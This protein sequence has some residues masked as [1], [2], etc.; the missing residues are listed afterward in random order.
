MIVAFLLVHEVVAYYIL[1]TYVSFSSGVHNSKPPADSLGWVFPFSLVGEP[2][3]KNLDY[4][5]IISSLVCCKLLETAA[6]LFSL[7]RQK[8]RSCCGLLFRWWWARS[9]RAT[10]A[11]VKPGP[12][13]SPIAVCIITKSRLYILDMV[14]V[15]LLSLH[16]R[17]TQ[18][19]TVE[20]RTI[21]NFVRIKC[22]SASAFPSDG[23]DFAPIGSKSR[24]F[25][26]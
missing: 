8:K 11:L 1:L 20:L 24:I 2:R 7:A 19:D 17:Y 6:I 9:D 18:S 14:V 3:N 13:V 12:W 5:G 16:R 4:S 22:P 23:N 26:E 25:T 21:D 10:D 15:L